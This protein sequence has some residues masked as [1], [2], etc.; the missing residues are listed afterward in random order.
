M[1]S[2]QKAASPATPAELVPAA[3]PDVSPDLH[4]LAERSLLAH[5]YKLVRE[6]RAAEAAGRF[7]ASAKAPSATPR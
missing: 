7:T 1:N 5:L 2:L 4:P 6:G 3:Y